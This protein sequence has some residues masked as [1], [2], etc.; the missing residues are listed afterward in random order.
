V[1]TAGEGGEWSVA[2]PLGVADVRLHGAT[3]P[4]TAR[5]GRCAIGDV[6]PQESPTPRLRRR[7]DPGG[8]LTALRPAVP[9]VGRPAPIDV[10][11]V[12]PEISPAAGGFPLATVATAGVTAGVAAVFFSPIFAMLAGV[13]AVAVIG[14]WIGS[15]ATH[16]RSRQKRAEAE[17]IAV[18]RWGDAAVGVGP[19][20]LGIVLVT[21]ADRAVDWDQLKWSP[22]LAACVVVDEDRDDAL[23]DALECARCGG[24]DADRPLLVVI[25]GAEPTASGLLA[26]VLSGRVENTTLLWLGAPDAVPSGCRS[27]VTVAADGSGVLHRLDS[28]EMQAVQ[29]FGC[30]AAGSGRRS[31]TGNT[32]YATWK[33]AMSATSTERTPVRLVGWSWS[34][35]NSLRLPT[36]CRTSSTVWSTLLVEVARLGSTSSSP[37]SGLQ[38]L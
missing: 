4:S 14:R 5:G 36:S 20:D 3:V 11:V 1:F 34:L 12:V 28:G 19:A 25:D 22:S 15:I 26:R 7:P 37:P 21:T 17:A 2:T 8:R 35:T 27:S 23:A 33:S 31:S 13:S 24:A 16:R 9:T 30:A 32:G 10:E 29:W 18:S 6:P 38:A